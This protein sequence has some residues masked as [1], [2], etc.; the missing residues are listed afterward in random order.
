MCDLGCT[1]HYGCRLRLKGIQVSPSAMPER[2]ANRPQP[3]RS[4]QADQYG[5]AQA[6]DERGVPIIRN[7]GTAVSLKEWQSERTRVTE[8]WAAADAASMSNQ[9]RS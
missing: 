3:F 9:P 4:A 7:N 1:E 2:T 5:K 8:T 6:H